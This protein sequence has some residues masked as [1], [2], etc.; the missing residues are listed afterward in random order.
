MVTDWATDLSL[1]L[2]HDKMK[3][4]YFGTRNFVDHLNSLNYLCIDLGNGTIIP[5]EKEVKS[6]GVTLDSKLT[7]ELH[8]SSLERKVNRILYTLRFVRHCITETL[9]TR[10]VRAL[11]LPHLDYCNVVY[12]DIS[13]SLKARLNA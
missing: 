6:L 11:V 10:L 4:I 1:R 2:S 7:W 5:F 12:L 13:N 8:I 3:A 9:S